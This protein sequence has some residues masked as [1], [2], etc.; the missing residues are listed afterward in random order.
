[1]NVISI[2][3]C[4]L[5]TQLVRYSALFIPQGMFTRNVC[6]ERGVVYVSM[7]LI[8]EYESDGRIRSGISFPRT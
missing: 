6:H 1:M 7:N 5:V 8:V 2:I 4:V 3:L